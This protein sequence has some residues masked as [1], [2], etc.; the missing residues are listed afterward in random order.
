M[1]QLFLPPTIQRDMLLTRLAGEYHRQTGEH[2][3][4]ALFSVEV[5]LSQAVVDYV[6]NGA[7]RGLSPDGFWSW[8]E[9][10]VQHPNNTFTTQTA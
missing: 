3:A 8:L 6:L 9:E 1:K 7:E 5:V 4:D 10:S 2:P